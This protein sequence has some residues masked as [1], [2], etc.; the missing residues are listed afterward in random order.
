MT[1]GASDRLPSIDDLPSAFP[2]FPLT[3]ALLLPS[4]NLPLNIFEP[5]YLAMVDAALAGPRM[6]GMIQPKTGQDQAAQPALQSVGC[7]GKITSFSETEDGRYL[8][9]LSG[10]ARF[11][12][13]EELAATTPFRQVVGDFARFAHDLREPE[14][15][16]GVDRQAILST[17][18]GFLA[19][20]DLE[21]DW[22]SIESAPPEPLVNSLSM[23]LPFAPTEK[24]AL[25]EAQSLKERALTLVAL[26]EM[27]RPNGDDD[28][29]PALN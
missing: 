27:A 10:V 17:L 14:D 5:R 13:T 20:F 23:V 6:I 28:D 19:R 21:A 25:L 11:E 29:G 26:L 4:G 18:K 2:V 15:T 7:L 12:V 8:I 3:G 24:Q 1:R 16:A 9:T 22:E